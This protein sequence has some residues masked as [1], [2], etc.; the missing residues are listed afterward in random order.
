[1]H[2]DK[3]QGGAPGQPSRSETDDASSPPRS[4]S[5]ALGSASAGNV[6]R[7]G[8]AADRQAAY[9]RRQQ[10]LSEDLP[11]QDNHHGR[12]SLAGA[13]SNGLIGAGTSSNAAAYVT[14]TSTQSR[15]ESP[16]QAVS[17]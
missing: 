8:S 7:Y 10:G 14:A 4:L 12:R 17:P 1:M 15:P 2:P 6:A 11:R 3:G 9:R 16:C 5:G 13:V